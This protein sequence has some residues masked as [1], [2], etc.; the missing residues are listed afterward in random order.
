MTAPF[1]CISTP[2][3]ASLVKFFNLSDFQ[4]PP[5]TSRFMVASLPAA[6]AAHAGATTQTATSIH[7]RIGNIGPFYPLR[8]PSVNVLPEWGQTFSGG[9]E[10]PTVGQG[11]WHVPFDQFRRQS[12]YGDSVS[13]WRSDN[14]GK[15]KDGN[16]SGDY[17]GIDE[18]FKKRFS[19]T[20]ASAPW[21]R[22]SLF[23]LAKA[24]DAEDPNAEIAVVLK[25]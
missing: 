6:C 22:Q 20:A 10:D 15:D 3:T 19:S 13:D 18:L 2:T 21:L 11:G 12:L 5:G 4:V 17:L 24:D 16:G 1:V 8:L 9:G 25:D 14:S 7:N 23:D